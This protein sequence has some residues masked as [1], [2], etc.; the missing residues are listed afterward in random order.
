MSWSV[1]LAAVL[2]GVGLFLLLSLLA[3]KR[4]GRR[5]A[6]PTPDRA[7]NF[8]TQELPVEAVRAAVQDLHILAEIVYC[9]SEEVI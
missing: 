6:V 4:R 3:K 7:G 1:W 5:A 2:L 8:V 9:E